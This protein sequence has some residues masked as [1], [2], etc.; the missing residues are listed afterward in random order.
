MILSWKKK[1]NVGRCF[2]KKSYHNYSISIVFKHN[3]MFIIATVVFQLHR[4]IIPAEPYLGILWP[5][6]NILVGTL[7]LIYK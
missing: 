6:V 4:S 2:I 7:N 1:N 3:I 5:G